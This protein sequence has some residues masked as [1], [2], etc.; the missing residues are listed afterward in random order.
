MSSQTP[1]LERVAIV[2]ST[3]QLGSQ[4]VRAFGAPA[5]ALDHREV[6]VED[7]ETILA[8]L[9]RHRP[10]FVLSTAAYHNVAD[11]ERHPARA[12][13]VNA[14]GTEHL[15][16]AC[17]V[18]GVGF[19]YVSTDY[20]F[21]GALGRPYKEDDRPNPL[22]L[23]GISKL[24]GEMAA[25]R[26]GGAYVFRTSG[27]YGAGGARG[28]GSPFAARI[29]QQAQ[30]D[31]PIRVV[32]DVRFSPSYAPHVAT[33]IKQILEKAPPGIYHVTNAGSCTWHE[34]AV[35]ALRVAGYPSEIEAVSQA[36]FD[37]S[38]RRPANSSLRMPRQRMPASR[39]RRRG[40]KALRP[41]LR[42]RGSA[43]NP[44]EARDSADRGVVNTSG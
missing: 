39:N 8:A 18:A 35:A 40:S 7:A 34:F 14:V 26:Y 28:K 10:T 24:A 43:S 6:A 27:L 33:S 36:S 41:T 44:A 32:D 42:R 25:L 22:Q 20:V 19:G 11:C 29:V 31:E 1:R 13:A 16:A 38:I 2:G 21:D 5:I 9:R 4:L 3:G 30:R 37:T 17:S 23:Y 12:F 15:A